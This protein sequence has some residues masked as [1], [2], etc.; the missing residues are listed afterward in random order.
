MSAQ[1]PPVEFELTEADGFTVFVSPRGA[2]LTG[3]TYRGQTVMPRIDAIEHPLSAGELLLPWPNRIR[4]GKW[5]LDGASGAAA[6]NEP[7]RGNAIHGLVRALD[8]ALEHASANELSLRARLEPS[9][10]FPFSLDITQRFRISRAALESETTLFNPGLERVP[11]AFGA[12]PYLGIAG[13]P[14]TELTLALEARE[15]LITD[16]RLLPVD[17]AAVSGALDLAAPQR[18]SEL[19]LDHAFTGLSARPLAV[20][21]AVDGRSLSVF[22]DEHIRYLQVFTPAERGAELGPGGWVAIEPMTAPADALNSGEG[23]QWLDSGETASVRW[24][25]RAA[26]AW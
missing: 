9:A 21:A 8:F 12:H 15:V 17:R 3:A 22:G 24:S 1:R 26:G 2:T 23:V 16:D 14:A 4:D 10:A 7:A 6:V 18:L 11:W 13:L 25:I 5:N 20:L 19:V